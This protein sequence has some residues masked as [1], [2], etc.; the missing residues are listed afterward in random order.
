ME[1]KITDSTS[2]EMKAGADAPAFSD[3]QSLRP[4]M[5][6]REAR[7][8]APLALAFL[9]DAF[10][11]LCIRTMVVQNHT[12][13]PDG[14]NRL[15]SQYAKAGT[16]AAAMAAILPDLTEEEESVY[17]RGRNAKSKTMAKHASMSDYRQATGFEALIGYLY[18]TGQEERALTIIEKGIMQNENA[19]GQTE[20]E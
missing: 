8:M 7:Q 17:R 16:Q 5:T 20:N 11:E 12:L 15:S 4:H 6:A 14:L 2:C 18:L 3:A 10:Y 19:A 9:G 1:Q 13:N